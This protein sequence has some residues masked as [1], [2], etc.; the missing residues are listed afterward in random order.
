V[1]AL[2]AVSARVLLRAAS[3]AAAVWLPVLVLRAASAAVVV[4]WLPVLVL[5]AASAATP[6]PPLPLLQQARVISASVL[7]R[8]R[9]GRRR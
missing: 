4:V 2:R 3:A 1:L 9:L 5:R 8:E 6:V 7:R